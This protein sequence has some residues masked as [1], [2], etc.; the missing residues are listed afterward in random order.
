MGLVVLPEQI[1]MGK[2][3][4]TRRII[5]LGHVC[6]LGEA[7][8][9][10]RVLLKQLRRAPKI[11][12]QVPLLVE[13]IHGCQVLARNSLPTPTLP[14]RLRLQ[15]HLPLQNQSKALI[16]RTRTRSAQQSHLVLKNRRSQITQPIPH[17]KPLRSRAIRLSYKVRF[18]GCRLAVELH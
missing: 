1:Q 18:G 11:S 3:P 9:V 13:E 2:P 7:W 16:S 5:S 10:R 14:L 15:H 12:S 6:P 4:N 8:K 17:R